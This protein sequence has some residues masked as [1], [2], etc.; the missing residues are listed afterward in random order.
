MPVIRKCNTA[1]DYILIVGKLS[2]MEWNEHENPN[3]DSEPAK[4][5][6]NFPDH[7]FDW[8]ILLTAPTNA[9][10]RKIMES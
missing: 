10:L 7:K 6:R 3:K 5:L 1:S 2:H 8:K 4:H 9:K